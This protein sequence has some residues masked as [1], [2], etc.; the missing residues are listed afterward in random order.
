MYID[1]KNSNYH[2]IAPTIDGKAYVWGSNAC[3]VLGNGRENDWNTYYR[4]EVNE[5]LKDKQII[6][7]ADMMESKQIFNQT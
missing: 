2:S 5:A 3:G 4:P 6:R 1:F 7:Y